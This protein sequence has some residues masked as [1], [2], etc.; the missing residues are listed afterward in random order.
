MLVDL[1]TNGEILIWRRMGFGLL[2]RNRSVEGA[3]FHG[4][5]AVLEPS[6][7]KNR[8]NNSEKL[9]FSL[10]YDLDKEK[11]FRNC[12][13]GWSARSEFFGPAYFGNRRFIRHPLRSSIRRNGGLELRW[14]QRKTHKRTSHYVDQKE[15]PDSVAKGALRAGIEL[16]CGKRVGHLKNFCRGAFAALSQRDALAIGMLRSFRRNI[17]VVGMRRAGA[18]L[19]LYNGVF[20]RARNWYHETKCWICLHRLFR[21]LFPV[22]RFQ[23]RTVRKTYS[24]LTGCWKTGSGVRTG[25]AIEKR[26]IQAMWALASPQTL[27]GGLRRSFSTP[28][29]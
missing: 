29:K 5:N 6:M 11:N 20:C 16:A 8:Q 23:I 13:S 26:D 22:C 3:H 25:A 7:G 24:T 21:N 4:L 15:L 17:E 12:G 18:I 27:N 10:Q 9:L 2:L 28:V 14:S 19:S 1:G